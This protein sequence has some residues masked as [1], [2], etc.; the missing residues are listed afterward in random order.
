MSA[1]AVP[2]KVKGI[3]ICDEVFGS[4]VEANVYT[5]ECVRQD[6]AADDF[7]AA[8]MVSEVAGILYE[9]EKSG[10][11]ASAIPHILGLLELLT[12]EQQLDLARRLPP[13]MSP[14]ARAL[15]TTPALI[16]ANV[17]H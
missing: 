17:S 7:G 12:P 2:P 8:C 13:L 1:A 5:L 9:R 16:D 10:K 3:A 11:P 4:D 14:E 6:I 15:L